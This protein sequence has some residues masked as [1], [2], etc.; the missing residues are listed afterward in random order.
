M[1]IYLLMSKIVGANPKL[2]YKNTCLF[3][4]NQH[5]E[6]LTL[7][8]ILINTLTDG[9]KVFGGQTYKLPTTEAPTTQKSWHPWSTQHNTRY[10]GTVRADLS[11]NAMIVTDHQCQCLCGKLWGICKQVIVKGFQVIVIIM[12]VIMQ[13]ISLKTHH[14]CR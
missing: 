7:Q 1:L 8:N 2:S 3:K 6:L 5:S 9:S 4:F 13:K 11:T 10:L 12:H 14:E